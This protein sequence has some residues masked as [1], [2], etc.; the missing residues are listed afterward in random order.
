MSTTSMEHEIVGPTSFTPATSLSVRMECQ[1]VCTY[2]GRNGPLTLLDT[3]TK[4][5]KEGSETLAHNGQPNSFR[6]GSF[7]FSMQ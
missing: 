2:A 1:A 7:Q 3:Q 5:L 6:S 4:C